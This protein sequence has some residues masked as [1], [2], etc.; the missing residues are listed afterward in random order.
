MTEFATHTTAT[1]I[2]HV[3]ADLFMQRGYK[4]VSITDIINAA[5][6]TKPTLYYHFAD[7]EEVYVRM[8]EQMLADL[9]ERFEAAKLGKA[10]F[11]EQL[12]AVTAVFM[13]SKENDISGMRRDMREHLSPTAQQRLTAAFFCH[14][15]Q[16]VHNLMLAGLENGVIQRHTAPELTWL[17]LGLTNAFSTSDESNSLRKHQL[18]GQ[19]TTIS[20]NTLV[21]LFLYGVATP[22]PAKGE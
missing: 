4:A 19:P 17:F 10:T 2:L 7:K 16:P 12:I 3:A 14:L 18:S 6:I 5:D 11:V 13:E 1:K 15:F 8:G 21:H 20:A 22:Q 9:H